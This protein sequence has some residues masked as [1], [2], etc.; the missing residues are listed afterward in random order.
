MLL[1]ELLKNIDVLNITG[2]TD[3]EIRGVTYDRERLCRVISLYV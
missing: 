3:T 2:N 1:N